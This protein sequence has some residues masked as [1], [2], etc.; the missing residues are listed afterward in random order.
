VSV[1]LAL[2]LAA[3][4]PSEAEVGGRS[5]AVA[6]QALH[7]YSRCVVIERPVEVRA[8]LGSDFKDKHYGFKLHKLINRRADC[9]GIEVPSGVYRSGGLLWGG[10]F[11]EELLRRDKILDDLAARTALRPELPMIRARDNRELTAIC[12]VRENPAATTNLLRTLPATSEEL[13]ALKAIGSTVS[14]CIPKGTR[15]EFTRDGLRALL[16]LAAY[17]LAIHNAGAA[18]SSREAAK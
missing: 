4:A 11:A 9:P 17:R 8:L 3:T 10:A 18:P 14:G 15:A 2:M 13:A 5:S 6:R 12:V 16:A 1:L 7:E